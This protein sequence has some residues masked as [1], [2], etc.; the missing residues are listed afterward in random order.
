MSWYCTE[1]KTSSALL[2]SMSHVS[3]RLEGVEQARRHAIIMWRMK[4]F[5]CEHFLPGNREPLCSTVRGQP[6]HTAMEHL[7][8]NPT[9]LGMQTKAAALHITSSSKPN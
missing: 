8:V 4:S 2:P 6:S 7:L 9:S 5:Q 3:R 1:C